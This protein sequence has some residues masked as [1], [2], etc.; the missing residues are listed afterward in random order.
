[1]YVE[2]AGGVCT[3]KVL[4]LCIGLKLPVT[5]KLLGSYWEVSQLLVPVHPVTWSGIIADPALSRR[6]VWRPPEILISL[7]FPVS[8]GF[9]YVKFNISIRIVCLF[10][11][12]KYE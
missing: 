8:L 3:V 5:G 6:L 1:M 10:I 7:N 2:A 9:S 11:V 12:C 4:K